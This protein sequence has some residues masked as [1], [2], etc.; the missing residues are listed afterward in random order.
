VLPYDCLYEPADRAYVDV[1]HPKATTEAAAIH[2]TYA[3][4]DLWKSSLFQPS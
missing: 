2:S 1:L 3:S 4:E